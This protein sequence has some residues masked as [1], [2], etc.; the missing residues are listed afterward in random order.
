VIK[1]STKTCEPSGFGVGVSYG[2]GFDVGAFGLGYMG[3]GAVGGGLFYDGSTGASGGLFAEGGA[4]VY[5]G[6]YAAG[7]PATQEGIY[8]AGAFIGA[9]PAVFVTNA[10]SVQQLQGDFITMTLNAAAGPVQGSIQFSWDSS[11]GIFQLS[12]G[13]PIPFVSGGLG[14]S[15]SQVVTYTVTTASGCH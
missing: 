7:A 2:A 13:P 5:A 10:G 8:N 9:G 14:L 15:I 6:P 4:A 1:Q 12:A 3:T 11:N